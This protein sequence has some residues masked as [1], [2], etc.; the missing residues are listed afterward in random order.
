MIESLM[1]LHKCS[2]CPIRCQ[3]SRKPRSLFK[4]LGWE[5][6]SD[7]ILH[8]AAVPWTRRTFKEFSPRVH[9]NRR[10]AKTHEPGACFPYGGI[11]RGGLVGFG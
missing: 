11:G 8:A 3:A 7:A 1:N 2:T 9:Y 6:W 4:L 10:R 5:K